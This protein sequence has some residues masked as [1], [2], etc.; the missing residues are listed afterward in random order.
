MKR[1][2]GELPGTP[3]RTARAR[4]LRA[5][6]AAGD[7]L[8]AERKRFERELRHPDTTHTAGVGAD[9]SAHFL[10]D[11]PRTDDDAVWD[12]PG[13]ET[14]SRASGGNSGPVMP[15]TPYR[16]AMML[17]RA[18]K[19]PP[20]APPSPKLESPTSDITASIREALDAAERGLRA[21]VIA[22][23]QMERLARS[24]G[25]H[26][27]SSQSLETPGDTAA[28]LAAGDEDPEAQAYLQGVLRMIYGAGEDDEDESDEDAPARALRAA[29]KNARDGVTTHLLGDDSEREA[30]VA[31]RAH[32]RANAMSAPSA[33]TSSHS[34]RRESP[35]E[36][37]PSEQTFAFRTGDA[38]ALGAYPFSVFGTKATRT[39]VMASESIS[40]P[41]TIET[42]EPSI[43]GPPSP[44]DQLA[45]TP[46]LPPTPSWVTV[47]R[48]KSTSPETTAMFDK[49]HELERGFA[50]FVSS[51]DV[52]SEES[53]ENGKETFAAE[54]TTT[55]RTTKASQS[56]YRPATV[57]DVVGDTKAQNVASKPNAKQPSSVTVPKAQKA[58]PLR[59][60]AA[61]R[62]SDAKGSPD[63]TSALDPVA[64]EALDAMN[65]EAVKSRQS[66]APDNAP[67]NAALD[68]QTEQEANRKKEARSKVHELLGG[69]FDYD[70]IR[71][72]TRVSKAQRLIGTDARAVSVDAATLG[73]FVPVTPPRVAPD[74]TAR[75]RGVAQA[76]AAEMNA[77]AFPDFFADVREAAAFGAGASFGND[78]PQSV[79]I[80]TDVSIEAFRAAIRMEVAT[81]I[82]AS[83]S[84]VNADA[85]KMAKERKAA[86]S[87][88]RES[89]A[90]KSQRGNKRNARA[91][92][93]KRTPPPPKGAWRPP[94]EQPKK[95]NAG[96]AA[97]ESIEARAEAD[98]AS[99]RSRS[100]P[101]R[102]R[103]PVSEDGTY[104]ASSRRSSEAP[105]RL[106]ARGISA[107]EAGRRRGERAAKVAKAREDAERVREADMEKTER[108]AEARRAAAEKARARRVEVAFGRKAK[109]KAGGEEDDSEIGKSGKRTPKP[110]RPKNTEVKP[111]NLSK[112]NHTRN[113]SDLLAEREANFH[114][115]EVWEPSPEK[116]R[117]EED[118]TGVSGDSA[119]GT[120]AGRARHRS[121]ENE[122]ATSS[123]E[124]SWTSPRLAEAR[125]A[126][127]EL[128]RRSRAATRQSRVI[129]AAS[130]AAAP[131]IA[132][133]EEA[134]RDADA[135]AAA[136]ARAAAAASAAEALM[137][138]EAR[139]L[140]ERRKELYA[141]GKDADFVSAREPLSP[142]M[143]D[144][145]LM[146]SYS[147]MPDVY[148]AAARSVDASPSKPKLDPESFSLPLRVSASLAEVSPVKHGGKHVA[149]GPREPVQY[150]PSRLGGED[151]TTGDAYTAFDTFPGSMTKSTDGSFPAKTNK[152]TVPPFVFESTS[153]GVKTPPSPRSPAISWQM[154]AL[155]LPGV[156]VKQSMPVSFDD[157]LEVSVKETVKDVANVDAK[158]KEV[159]IPVVLRRA[160]E[161]R[162][163]LAAGRDPMRNSSDKGVAA[164]KNNV[165]DPSHQ[166]PGRRLLFRGDDLTYVPPAEIVVDDAAASE[167]GAEISARHKTWLDK[168]GD[169]SSQFADDS[170]DNSDDGSA[171]DNLDGELTRAAATAVAQKLAQ[172]NREEK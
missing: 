109:V 48:R 170:F 27:T 12:L 113:K 73:A 117:G 82:V 149:G 126:R 89:V 64:K 135:A 153:D 156:A 92:D 77:C 154:G 8:R 96:D 25:T 42:K 19:E 142:E 84:G 88:L 146:A 87:A 102:E 53:G 1:L 2:A 45:P 30:V 80:D 59:V 5:M 66:P 52:G 24:R 148:A 124:K 108:A 160:A 69:A 157:Q 63:G 60:D 106:S 100:A 83:A 15:T 9:D 155:E 143:E 144:A 139:R 74:G 101:A 151:D 141:R 131:A 136:A 159:E 79:V 17:A 158:K 55:T 161:A 20:V 99:G 140:R 90:P 116:V 132:A 49:F 71:A 54:T 26:V 123:N 56:P 162:A 21:S 35:S 39:T 152:T 22:T 166:I 91:V 107:R 41:T 164:R 97:R 6:S 94:P 3:R 145:P 38:T 78:D 165:D 44:S 104:A 172:A 36:A 7:I 93:R 65:P 168:A 46:G 110:T 163:V 137:M 103:P 18:A 40:P 114:D 31:R 43:A 95:M 33:M 86:T 16:E 138:A 76:V 85:T 23:D 70:E 14:P 68:Q 122:N 57:N 98:Y 58:P 125:R 133:A 150:D 29:V 72:V 120:P 167:D 127:D 119:H 11:S 112:G 13:D 128:K 129:H 75:P 32:T 147:S 50:E 171:D 81:R 115:P 130:E 28:L 10:A 169:A 121:D 34:S 67:W 105:G 118:E 4:R 62:K 111:F 37:K 51:P 47:E 134:R 61:T